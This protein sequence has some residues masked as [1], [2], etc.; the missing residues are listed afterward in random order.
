MDSKIDKQSSSNANTDLKK[1]VKKEPLTTDDS[2]NKREVHLK[3][4]ADSISDNG[5][6]C[7]L[8]MIAN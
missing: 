4:L 3:E 2:N 7:Y 1:T 5:M 8:W 6:D